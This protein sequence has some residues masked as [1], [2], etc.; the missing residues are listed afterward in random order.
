[1][2]TRE[3]ALSDIR[4]TGETVA[5]WARRNGFSQSAV[6]AVIYGASKGIWGESHL[7][8]VRLGMK[9]GV[10]NEL[11]NLKNSV[12]TTATTFSESR[13]GDRCSPER[14]NDPVNH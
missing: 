5:G 11:G 8:A 13:C 4:A 1:M 14:C 2:K 12:A 10:S 7:V 9:E 3:Q 6:R